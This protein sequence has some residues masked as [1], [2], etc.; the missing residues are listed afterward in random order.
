M[1][2]SFKRVFLHKRYPLTISRGTITGSEN[3]FL[4]L[5]CFGESGL[6]ELAGTTTEAGENCDSGI[7][8]LTPFLQA[9]PEDEVSI[10]DVLRRAADAGIRPRARA[11][12]DM[13]LWDAFG[14]ACRQPLWR[15]FGLRRASNPTSITIGIN[16]PE[17]TRERVPEMLARTG[18]KYL[19][20]KLGSPEGLELDR[21]H[22]AAAA[23]AAAPF[24]VS[25]RVDANG[26]WSLDDAL[27]MQHELAAK[28]VDYLEQ[29]FPKGAEE[30]LPL[31]FK[32]R[33]LP[34]FVDESCW[35]AA[36]VPKLADCVDGVNLKLM[37]CGGLTEALRIVATARACGL[38]TMIGCMGESNVSISAGAAIGSLFDHIDLDSQ[39]NLLDDPT[40]GAKMEHGV[41][42]PN[43]LPGH[44]ASLHVEKIQNAKDN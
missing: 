6:G 23:E 36:D 32:R 44:G 29:P 26:G 19:K 3:L 15:V 12:L 30:L 9:L 39:L 35:Y 5:R 37:K 31:L 27:V 42:L 20:V 14:K 4:T 24:H 41:V 25:I 28:G 18:A 33:E 1:Q 16:P 22:F 7:R 11:A 21:A 40:D 17:V 38:G 34:V 13:A 8:E 43:C 10:A 2:F